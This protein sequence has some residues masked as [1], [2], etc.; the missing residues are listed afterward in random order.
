[1]KYKYGGGF[2]LFCVFSGFRNKWS[3]MAGWTS[4]HRN[5]QAST[6]AKCDTEELFVTL[7]HPSRDLKRAAKAEGKLN[8]KYDVVDVLLSRSCTVCDCLTLTPQLG[9]RILF[10]D[11]QMRV[12]YTGKDFKFDTFTELKP[13][14]NPYCPCEVICDRRE[15]FDGARVNFDSDYYGVGMLGGLDTAFPLGCGFHFQGTFIGAIV[16]G[17]NLYK[18]EELLSKCVDFCT[19]EARPIID[20]REKQYVAIPM[21]QVEGRLGWETKCY[22]KGQLRLVIG[23]SFTHLWN[24]PQLRRYHTGIESVSNSSHASTIGLHGGTFGAELL[25]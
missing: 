12:D 3:L 13:E 15:L 4:F 16:A 10:L 19:K 11:Q 25:F 17:R 5:A 9:M 8:L 18:H 2:R 1:L 14:Y 24:V 23:Y 20:V 7:M 22:T 21:L 6:E